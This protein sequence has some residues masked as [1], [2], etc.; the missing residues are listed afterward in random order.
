VKSG[1]CQ[2]GTG[3][4]DRGLLIHHLQHALPR[5]EAAL[6]H[7]RDPAER[8]HR[9]REH[10]EIGVERH[11]AADRDAA[12][13]DLPAALPQHQQ[14]TDPEEERHARVE[15]SLQP[16]QAPVPPHVLFVRAPEAL[17]L[18]GLLAVRPDDA[19][20]RERFLDD[21]ADVRELCLDRLEAAVD[22][23]AEPLDRNGHER[24][25]H[26]RDERQPRID[27]QH[28]RDGDDEREDRRGRVHHRG[29]DHHAHGVEIVRGARHQVSRAVGLVE[30]ERKALE[31]AEEVVAQVVFDL[32]RDADD[33]SAHQVAEDAANDGETEQEQGVVRQLAAGHPRGK[34]IDGVLQHPR[35]ELL[36]AGGSGDAQKANR[37]GAAV[38]GEVGPQSAPGPRAR[39]SE[40]HECPV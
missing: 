5:C 11:E 2:V 12:L 40:G 34:I 37:E 6:D 31:A 38:A 36:E 8:N 18:R 1:A 32:A 24:E 29:A 28:H 21:R 25:R 3:V 13:D 39:R 14:R 7:V 19:H 23:T 9:P 33:D 10:H 4:H 26:E 22:G 20:A 27:R 30:R 15:Q 17:E 35:R 16:D